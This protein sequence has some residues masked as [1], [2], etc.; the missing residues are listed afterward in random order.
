[1]DLGIKG[2]KA[3]VAGASTGMGAASAR[4]L[5][6]EGVE[7]FVSARGEERLRHFV[8]TAS[9]ETG[10]VMHPV[11]ADHS[12]EAGRATLLAA[13]PDP[14]IL[15]ISC[16]PPGLT[17]DYLKIS[18]QNHRDSLET[19]YIAP[20]ELMR[21]SLEGMAARGFGRVVNI[22]TAGAKRPWEARLLSGPPRSALINFVHAI[23]KRYASKNVT[24]NNLLPGVFNTPNTLAHFTRLAEKKG[25][26]VEEEQFKMAQQLDIPAGRFGSM[27]EIGPFCAMLC[28]ANAS[29][30]TGQSIVIDGGSLISL[31]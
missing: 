18:P 17:E 7:V 10:G 6:A 4:A 19:T 27:D 30:I 20:I 21:A 23:S 11:V 2:R 26:S 15:V 3:I 24:L 22:T 31:F 8:E 9:R 5:A 14:D 12:T 16:G 1:V 13:C 28:S 29:F 25:T